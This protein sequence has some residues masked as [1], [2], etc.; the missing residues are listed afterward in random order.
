V[1]TKDGTKYRQLHIEDYLLMVS[2]EQR[3]QAEGYARRRIAGDD[4]AITDQRTNQLL[5]LVIRRENLNRAY[6]RVKRNKGSAGIDRMEVDELLPYLRENGDEL[7]RQIVEGKYKP[8]PVRRVEIPKEEKGKVRKLGIPTVVDRMVQQAIAQELTPLYEVQFS[9]NSFGFRPGRGAHDALRRCQQLADEGYV[10]MVSMD[11][12]AYFDTVNHSKL[13]EVLSR[14]V[15]DGRV[16]SLIH[17]YL[18]AGVM[19]KGSF[20]RTEEGVPQ[21][22]PLSPLLGN[23]MLNELDKELER[24][25]HRFV[26]YADD[27]MIFCKSR[28]AAERTMRNIVPYITGKLFLKVNLEKTTVA[29]ISRVKYLGYGFYRYKGKCRLRVHPKSVAKMRKR[30]KTLTCRGNRW[31]SDERKKKLGEYVRGWVNYF[32]L[33]DMKQLLTQ[34]DEWMRR[35]IRAV[36][37]KQWKRVRTRYKML[38][39]LRLEEWKVHEMA[40]CRRGPWRA[41]KM[42]NAVITKERLARAGYPSLLGQY[43]KVCENL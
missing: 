17:K 19:E 16:I 14:T 39:K 23:I 32:R 31:S 25:G 34:T 6:R 36:I 5:E 28:K 26:R 11:L 9:D 41:A 18:N 33:A 22:G 42:L 1:A 8:N 7:I 4:D 24:R 43:R 37:W 2:A 20:Q 10:Y 29:H 12:A 3:E 21:G 35:R 40:N 30:I 13:I 15:K 27:C 38:R